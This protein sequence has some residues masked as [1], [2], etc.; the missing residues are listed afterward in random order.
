VSLREEAHQHPLQHRVLA[1]DHAADLEQR[2]LEPLLRFCR[3]RGAVVD[4]L[5]LALAHFLSSPPLKDIR[6]QTFLSLG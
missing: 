2:L 6:K 5:L 4:E 1:C 3:G